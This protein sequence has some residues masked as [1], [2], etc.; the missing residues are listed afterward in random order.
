M[1][2]CM[3][4]RQKVGSLFGPIVQAVSIVDTTHGTVAICVH[5]PSNSEGIWEAV[6]WEFLAWIIA[7]DRP[8]LMH[9]KDAPLDFHGTSMDQSITTK[10]CIRSGECISTRTVMS[11]IG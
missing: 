11:P 5:S 9:L 3:Q 1:T 8:T 6:N 4:V 2:S 10:G 7:R